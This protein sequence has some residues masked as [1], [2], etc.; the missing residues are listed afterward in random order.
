MKETQFVARREA[1]WARWDRWLGIRPKDDHRKSSSAGSSW[2]ADPLAIPTSELA[3][4]FRALCYDLA[5]AEDRNYSS[6]LID[7]LQHRVLVAHQTLYSAKRRIGQAVVDFLVGGFPAAVR[8]E[9]RVVLVSAALFFVPLLT[10]LVLMQI[11][12]ESVYFLLSPQE[13]T[14]FEQLYSPHLQSTGRPAS[15]DWSMYSFYIAN[16]VRID[17][18][19]FAGGIAFGLGTVFYL[20]F[21]GMKIGAVAGYLTHLGFITSFWGFVA[22]HSSFE[23]LGAVFSGAAGLKIGLA[24]VAPG[25]RTRA[26][27]LREAA[28]RAIPLL[29][30]AAAMTFVAAIIEAFWSP[31]TVI[32]PWIKYAAG[33]ALWITLAAYFFLAGRSVSVTAA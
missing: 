20:I 32:A 6:Q 16:N 27:A 25:R 3:R 13:I 19:C 18:Q 4:R 29:Y 11:F 1:D 10:L 17:F 31:L 12:P 28:R 7:R 24:M 30:G 14:Q 21:N 2:V 15:M 26:F 5:L 22:G 8:R 9:K 23:L 33:I